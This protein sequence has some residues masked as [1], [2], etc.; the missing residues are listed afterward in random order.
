MSKVEKLIYDPIHGFIKMTG[1][2]R[3][4]ID[5][6]IFKR[7]QY[8]KQL[9]A[10]YYVFI[11]A[12]HH[13][14]EHSLGVSHLAE[15]MALNLKHNQP[16]L[17]ITDREIELLKVAALCHD[18]GHGPIS[19]AFDSEV[20][21]RLI[22]DT[23]TSVPEHEERSGYLLRQ[24]IAENNLSISEEEVKWICCA[25]HPTREDLEKYSRPFL[26][27]I[28]ANPIHGIDVDKF[29]YL[30][31]D[32]YNI[33]LDYHVNSDRLISEARVID[34]HICWPIKLANTILNLFTVR[35]QFLREV[36]N[37]PVVKAIEYMYTDATLSAIAYL[38]L[39]E[40]LLKNDFKDLTDVIYTLIEYDT[41]PQTKTSRDILARI[42]TRDLYQYLGEIS[43]QNS[44]QYTRLLKKVSDS[45]RMQANNIDPE[46]IIVHQLNLG[47]SNSG[48]YP[49][50]EVGF[51]QYGEPNK[52]IDLPK[53]D[54][55]MILPASFSEK[56]TI[57]IF[58]KYPKKTAP[59]EAIQKWMAD[60]QR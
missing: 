50:K 36:C 16:E 37:H 53:K 32:P 27:E 46:Q 13:R 21:P 58:S 57:R 47:Y 42:K 11:G 38:R 25:I 28:L 34:N 19:H 20:I 3:D 48:T 24:M 18:L 51:F 40:R 44:S 29:D 26:L 14:F 6:S 7:L 31:R 2:P 5:T 56:Y 17:E 35:Y 39:R 41:S 23:L 43:V 22:D 52:V 59:T 33:G 12:S 30:R 1:L 45:T 54:I 8:I 55:S 4:I 49:L 10:V 60:I 9:G 15:K